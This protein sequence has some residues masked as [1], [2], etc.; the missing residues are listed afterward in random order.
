MN[1][2]TNSSAAACLYA[3]AYAAQYEQRNL[4]LA[5]QLYQDL[6]STH[7]NA[8]E[9]DYSRMQLHSMF[10][11]TVPQ[12]IRVDAEIALLETQLRQ[13]SARSTDRYLVQSAV[14]Q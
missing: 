4:P 13:V 6:L 9:A 14:T 12:R 11:Q 5:M 10:T 8:L 1:P 3:A 2:E 7:P